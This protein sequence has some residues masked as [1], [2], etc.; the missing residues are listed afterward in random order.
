MPEIKIIDKPKLK[1]F[2]RTIT[3]LT[4]TSV[5]WGFWIYLFLPLVNVVLWLFGI[6]YFYI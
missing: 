2:L 5:M 6:R 3:E 4:F 1:T